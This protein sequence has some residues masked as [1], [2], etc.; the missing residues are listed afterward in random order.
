MAIVQG[1]GREPSEVPAKEWT[2]RSLP[3]RIRL[4]T[5][6]PGHGEPITDVLIGQGMM[7]LGG[8]GYGGKG[9]PRPVEVLQLGGQ[10]PHG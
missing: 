6:R 7:W 4:R 10:G 8:G 1:E 2:G 5:F 9:L 3:G